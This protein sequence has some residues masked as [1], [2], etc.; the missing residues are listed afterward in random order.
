MRDTASHATFEVMGSAFEVH[1]LTGSESISNLFTYEISCSAKLP[2]PRASDVIGAE[3][4]LVLLDAEGRSR[5]V[6]GFI[7]EARA[8]AGD[9]EEGEI[10]FVLRP[11]VFDLTL[12]RA[13]RTLQAATSLEIIQKVL[14]K[15]AG[16]T[17][18]A[19]SSGAPIAYRAQRAE[20]DWAFIERTL[21]DAGLLYWFDHNK[22]SALV[23]ADGLS[24]ADPLEG[25]P[26]P[27][28]TESFVGG[29]DEGILE[30]G[31]G[32]AAGFSAHAAKG[33]RWEKPALDISA[34]AGGGA[35]ESYEY[36]AEV[37]GLKT[38]GESLLKQAAGRAYKKRIT[39]VMRSIR[40]A[41]GVALA[42][43]DR[44]DIEG[45]YV[46]LSIALATET[47][48]ERSPFISFTWSFTAAEA[49]AAPQPEPPPPRRTHTGLSYGVVTASAGDEVFPNEAG[50]V[51]AQLHWDRSGS[52][53]A[54]SG[55]WVRVAQRLAPGSMMMPRTGWVL[56]TIGQRGSA[57]APIGLG[58]IFDGEH[59]P[60]YSLPANKTRVVYKTATTPGGGSFNEIHFE[61]KKGAEVMHMHASRDAEVLT[62][63]IKSEIIHNDAEHKV[64]GQ[65]TITLK[66]SMGSQ[67]TLTQTTSVGGDEK[68]TVGGDMSKEA[69]GN[70]SISIAGDRTV[71]GKANHSTSVKH[72]RKLKVGAAL[73]DISLGD[74]R[75]EA[76]AALTLVGGAVLRVAGQ[77]INRKVGPLWV[78]TVGG[79]KYVRAGNS[80]GESAAKNTTETIGGSVVLKAGTT[81]NEDAS[82]SGSYTVLGKVQGTAKEGLIEAHDLI[83]IRCG[84]SVLQIDP[85]GVTLS[86]AQI[87]LN[88]EELEL[89]TSVIE[90]N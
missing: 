13:S 61:D 37:P 41:P 90:H 45:R 68:V 38:V 46:V 26:I 31:S 86:S 10:H 77:S 63:S 1:A 25:D 67:V 88:G 29:I 54:S 55:T 81:I 20:S 59:P 50:Q 82:E 16:A 72:D 14:G 66:S 56:A 85:K 21:S 34:S 9:N 84:K 30:L 78:E 58:R 70:E 53:S 6:R 44:A 60:S 27:V 43:D 40:G 64:D 35:Y 42:I 17:R 32:N 69:S 33:F 75:R 3:G 11:P 12:G 83:E 23:I 15:H 8:R 79:V 18:F 49:G 71:R 73:L 24:A 19:F 87:E 51:R 76:M 39:G 65:Q 57:D 4:S 2:L 89:V 22:G 28:L 47:A 7:A 52:F 5:S 62:R 80:V 74:I 36:V 48:G